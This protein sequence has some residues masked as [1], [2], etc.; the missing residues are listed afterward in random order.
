VA[1][2]AAV[3]KGE[4]LARLDVSDL[5]ARKVRLE[6]EREVARAKLAAAGEIQDASV[7]RSELWQLRTVASAKQ[8]QAELTALDREIARLESLF[9]DQLVKASDIEPLRRKRET[10]AARVGTFSA[11]ASAGRAGLGKQRVA[12]VDAHA[13]VVN[14]RLEPL[15]EQLRVAE[16]ALAELDVQMAGAILR[17][18]EDAIVA[19]IDHRAGEVVAA[20]LSVVTLTAGRRGVVV[21][22]VPEARSTLVHVGDAVTVSGRMPLTGSWRGRIIE[23]APDVAELPI[24]FR[25]SPSVPAWGRR[26]I[27]QTDGGG[28]LP[29]EEIR[30]AF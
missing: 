19:N 17:A 12:G 21:A 25:V 18:P 27:V 11:A 6:A 7:L 3:K 9:K 4:E 10:L 13:E 29:G 8:D 5:Q 23:A 30:V 20:G 15:R 24:R 14:Q 26:V 1:L 16:A 2:G 28:W 22:F